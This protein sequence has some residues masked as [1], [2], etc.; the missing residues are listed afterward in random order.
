MTPFR[1]FLS[2]VLPQD[3]DDWAFIVG[4]ALIIVFILALDGQ[5]LEDFTPISTF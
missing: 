1:Y 2:R 3:L 5:Q 4:V